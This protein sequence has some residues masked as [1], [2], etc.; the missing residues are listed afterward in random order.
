MSLADHFLQQKAADLSRRVV[1]IDQ[2]ARDVLRGYQWPGNVR[3]LENVMERAVVLTRGSVI[4]RDDLPPH[5]LDE[6]RIGV[7][8]GSSAAST[9]D[10]YPFPT[11]G[12]SLREA[13]EAPERRIILETLE[14]S[15]WNRQ[16]TADVLEINRTTLY[17]KMKRYG[18]DRRVA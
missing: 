5:L 9:G 13:L 12:L 6:P 18:L 1:G 16:R 11:E 15:G 8:P 10:A 17:K 2:A 4:T 14:R 7:R 3:E